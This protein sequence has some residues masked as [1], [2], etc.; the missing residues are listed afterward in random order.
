MYDSFKITILLIRLKNA[1]LDIFRIYL[2]QIISSKR[3]R[4]KILVLKVTEN[5]YIPFL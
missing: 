4:V 2:T 1:F 5:N 3:Y